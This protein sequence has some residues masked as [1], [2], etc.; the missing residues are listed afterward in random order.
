MATPTGTIGMNNVMT[1]L[2]ISGVT[3]LGDAD[4][5]ALAG[6]PSGIISMNDL[7]GKSNITTTNH[8]VTMG[9]TVTTGKIA[10]TL[11]GYSSINQIF[12]GLNPLYFRG[13]KIFQ[14]MHSS[15]S[16]AVQISIEGNHV[17]GNLFKTVRLITNVS[18]TTYTAAI[19]LSGGS[20]SNVPA[21]NGNPSY[22]YFT[23]S[24]NLPNRITIQFTY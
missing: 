18:D 23:I 11:T 4:V 10:N 1:E 17:A 22:T 24:S 12:G 8:V 13:Y 5:R 6:K 15:L 7:R 9:S 2:G 3:S 20:F 19:L 21:G 14:I 16:N